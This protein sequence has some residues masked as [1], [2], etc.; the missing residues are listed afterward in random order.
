MGDSS[1]NPEARAGRAG[2]R[3]QRRRLQLWRLWQRPVGQRLLASRDEIER[4]FG[5][6]SN[7]GVGFKGLLAWARRQHRVERW[8][9]G[10]VLLYHAYLATKPHAA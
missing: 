4:T 5:H 6:S 2:R 7:L 9:W 1:K 10:K 3:R 8:M